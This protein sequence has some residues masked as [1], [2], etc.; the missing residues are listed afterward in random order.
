MLCENAAIDEILTSRLAAPGVQKS[1]INY[2][3]CVRES[4]KNA[5]GNGG[6]RV[7]TPLCVWLCFKQNT[8]RKETR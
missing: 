1:S 7:D 3:N 6:I 8:E 5:M 2:G 4:L